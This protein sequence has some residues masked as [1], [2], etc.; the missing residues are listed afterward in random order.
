MSLQNIEDRV[1]TL[2]GR[3]LITHEDNST[4]YVTV[5]RAD[6]PTIAGT[7]FN[8]A[9]FSNLQGDIY[10]EVQYNTPTYSGSA[11]TL[12]LPLTSYETGKIVNIKAPATFS[13]YPTLNINGLGAKTVNSML[14][15]NQKYTLVYNGTSFDVISNTSEDVFYTASYVNQ[16]LESGQLI[17]ASNWVV[18]K[19]SARN[20]RFLALPGDQTQAR[21]TNI[22]NVF[23]DTYTPTSSNSYNINETGITLDIKFPYPVAINTMRTYLTT[24]SS[25]NFDYATISGSNDGNSYTELNRS[26]SRQTAKGNKSLNNSTAYLYYRIYV[27][28]SSSSSSTYP[29]IY[30]AQT[31]NYY[32]QNFTCNAPINSYKNGMIIR[33]RPNSSASL[34]RLNINGLGSKKVNTNFVTNKEYV[35]MYNGTS[36]DSI[37][38]PQVITTSGSY[39]LRYSKYYCVA[40]GAG[41][42]SGTS[43][44]YT[45]YAGGGEGGLVAGIFT[46][47]SSSTS[48]TVGVGGAGSYTNTGA[49]QD[50]GNTQIGSFIAY[51]GAGGVRSSSGYTHGA[52]GKARG[53]AILEGGTAT[54]TA[55]SSVVYTEG[56]TIEG[57]SFGQGGSSATHDGDHGAVILYPLL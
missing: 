2:P 24:T 40:I 15:L 8:R 6:E 34:P 11:M 12:D 13:S 26:T 37:S 27:R 10:T 21:N 31:Y 1:P 30:Y 17:P 53:G 9:L 25:T 7:S 55:G 47:K 23:N 43:T 42:G 52:G 56:H 45:G 44:S 48:I 36:W 35:L 39:S 19:R 54:G 57:L 18:N 46:P 50:G 4:E 3:Y 32:V 29:A 5:T 41:G 22:P 49:G 38:T 51:G 16:T 33:I 14:A 28:R 20:E